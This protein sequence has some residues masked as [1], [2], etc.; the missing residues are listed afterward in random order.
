MTDILP[1]PAQLGAFLA[2][3]L[4]LALTPGPGV[5]Y[6][7]TRSISQGRSAGLASTGGVA[8]GNLAN[9]VAASAGLAA[10]MSSSAGAFEIVKFSGALYLVYLGITTLR[11]PRSDPQ[12]PAIDAASRAKSFRNGFLVALL[13]PKTTM[14]FGAFLP[15]FMSDAASP[16]IQG[17]ALGALFVAIA[18]ITDTAYAFSA[19]SLSSL[20]ARKPACR[21]AG[22]Y[23]SGSIY[24]GLGLLALFS[25]PRTER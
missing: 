25:G 23:L 10:L 24:I 16:L 17:A 12:A 3:S 21:S 15:Q 8:L 19:G 7:V 6:I 13:N 20:L 18:A 4:V 22:R 11:S 14:F 2:A 9:A 5:I 1:S